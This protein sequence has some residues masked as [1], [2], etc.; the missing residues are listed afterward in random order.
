M[1]AEADVLEIFDWLDFFVKIGYLADA[2]LELLCRTI[3]SQNKGTKV[4][5]DILR[6][7]KTLN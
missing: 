1:P 3:G 6:S 2:S 5:Q 4:G 7:H